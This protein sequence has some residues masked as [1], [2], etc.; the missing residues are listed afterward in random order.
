MIVDAILVGLIFYFT[1]PLLTGYCA[2]Q[3]GRSFWLWFVIG[4]FLPIVSFLLI[5]ILIYF[6]EK[7]TP[8]HRLSRRE[9]VE[10]EKLVSALLSSTHSEVA[11]HPNE[12]RDAKNLNSGIESH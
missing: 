3:Y 5:F 7:T 10:S 12:K 8:L 4:C 11:D 6:D 2:L 1:F 9:R